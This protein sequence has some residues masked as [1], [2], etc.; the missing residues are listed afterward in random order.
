MYKVNEEFYECPI[1]AL[2]S[3]LGKKWV[4]DILWN[5]KDNKVRFGELQRTL[6]GC[7]KK[8]LVQQLELLIDNNIVI[9]N[10]KTINN[11]VESTY[12]LSEAGLLLLPIMKEMIK[13]GNGNL[14][15]KG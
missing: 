8:M 1:E 9:N 15:C 2:A 14:S 5:I 7:S 3:I 12:Y 4:P 6:E 10:K 11:A 13:W